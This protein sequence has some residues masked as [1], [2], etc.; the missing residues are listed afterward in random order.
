MGYW[1]FGGLRVWVEMVRKGR[2]LWMVLFMVKW[3]RDSCGEGL[4][5]GY[6]FYYYEYGVILRSRL[7]LG[8]EEWLSVVYF[9]YLLGNIIV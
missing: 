1:D 2:L 6:E 5:C 9:Y 3:W 7:D 4:L 8:S